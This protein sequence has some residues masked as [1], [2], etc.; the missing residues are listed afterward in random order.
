[1]AAVVRYIWMFRTAAVFFVLFGLSWLYTFGLTNYRPQHRPVGLALGAL[2]LVVGIFLFRRA[3][4]AIALSALGAGIVCLS[5]AAFA[6]QAHGPGI[7]FLAGLALVT[8]VYVV[9]SLRVL[10]GQGAVSTNHS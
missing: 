10:L 7:L 5:A 1:M 8:G 3:K 9:L 2:A 6:P 4:F